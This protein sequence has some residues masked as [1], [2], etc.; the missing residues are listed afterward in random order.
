MGVLAPRP[1][2]QRAGDGVLTVYVS[3]GNSDDKLSQAEWHRFFV[4]TGFRIRRAVEAGGGQVHGQ[5]VS[6]PASAWQNACWCAVLNPDSAEQLK[7]S[8]AHLAADFR[9]DSIAWA[10]AETTFIGASA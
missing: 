2:R 1:P 5:W 6:E 9:Q 10:E 3:I 4:E 8:L 7:M